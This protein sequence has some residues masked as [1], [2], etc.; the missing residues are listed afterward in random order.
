MNS[1]I[2]A[3]QN[4][5][6]TQIANT[7]VNYDD[8]LLFA[9]AN[10]PCAVNT[11]AEM[12]TLLV[13][14]QTFVNAVRATGGNNSTRWLLVQGPRTD[15]D[16]TDQLMNTLPTDPTPGRLM[17]EVHYYSPYNYTLMDADQWWGNQF[18]YWGQGYH[19]TTDTAHNPTWGEE[20]YMDAE[21]QKMTDQVREQRCAC[22][23]RR[24]R[25]N[26]T[27]VSTFGCEP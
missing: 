3:K 5:Y 21:F 6:W 15:I 16:L 20:A 7:F 8:H 13:Y 22:A 26:E 17:V 19:S 12:A 25:R 18:F 2:N 1:T 27:H 14:E 11:A 10:E 24:I 23:H 9:G 4:S